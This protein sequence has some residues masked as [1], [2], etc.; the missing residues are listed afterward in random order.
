MLDFSK[1]QKVYFRI[2][3]VV[4]TSHLQGQEEDVMLLRQLRDLTKQR[5]QAA[6]ASKRP[7]FADFPRRRAQ[8]GALWA[9]DGIDWLLQHRESDP[10]RFVFRSNSLSAK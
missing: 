9:Q 8:N 1:A 4:R 5:V 7:V 6:R 3:P 10:E 2:M